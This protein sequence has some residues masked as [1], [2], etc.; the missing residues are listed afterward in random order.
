[1][2]EQTLTIDDA[3]LPRFLYG[4]AWNEDQRSVSRLG[5][6]GPAVLQ[7]GGRSLYEGEFPR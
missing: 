2:P 7:G 6:S 5:P 3:E 1:M 4:T